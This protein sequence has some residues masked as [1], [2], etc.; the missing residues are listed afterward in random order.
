ML[1]REFFKSHSPVTL[2][3]EREYAVLS[4]PRCAHRVTVRE[5]RNIRDH[6]IR[7]SPLHLSKSHTRMIYGSDWLF[8][9][10]L[11]ITYFSKTAVK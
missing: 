11:E 6:A 5:G 4:P 2:R 3:G 1:R 8:P 9:A 7:Q 10:I